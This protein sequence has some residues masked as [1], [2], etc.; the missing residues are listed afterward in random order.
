MTDDEPPTHTFDEDDR[1]EQHSDRDEE[2][3]E[4]RRSWVEGAGTG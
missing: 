1:Q 4:P 2:E 3:A